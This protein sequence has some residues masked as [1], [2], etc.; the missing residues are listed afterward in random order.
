MPIVPGRGAQ[1]GKICPDARRLLPGKTFRATRRA[2]LNAVE[3]DSREGAK[4][5]R[6]ADT[7]GAL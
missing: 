2:R 6:R 1:P 3:Y 4:K 5:K 7:C